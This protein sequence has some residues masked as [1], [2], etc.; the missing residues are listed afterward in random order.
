MA[1]EY[2]RIG[3]TVVVIY[4][5]PSQLA[6]IPNGPPSPAP[7]FAL[8]L[9]LERC[10]V[11]CGPEPSVRIIGT[12][13]C[14]MPENVSRKKADT[15]SQ[16]DSLPSSLPQHILSNSNVANEPSSD[17]HQITTHHQWPAAATGRQQTHHSASALS[18]MPLNNYPLCKHE[19][20]RVLFNLLPVMIEVR[21]RPKEV[22]IGED[23]E[24]TG[25]IG[26]E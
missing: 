19:F 21:V 8:V 2:K 14:T 26:Q 4:V 12:P 7:D 20:N 25:L 22:I 3:V 9:G 10:R 5:P 18:P 15:N 13:N 17:Q 11:A 23:D 16:D 6:N 1:T 24:N